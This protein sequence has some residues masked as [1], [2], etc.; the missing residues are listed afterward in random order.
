M[1]AHGLIA[2]TILVVAALGVDFLAPL[3]LSS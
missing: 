1:T 2:A 3:F